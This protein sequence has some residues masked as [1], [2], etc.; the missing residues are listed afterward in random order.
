MCG[1]FAQTTPADVLVRLFKLVRPISVSPRFNLAPTQPVVAIRASPNGRFHQ[2]L[3]WG[4]VPPWAPDLKHGARLI[5]ARSETIF[6]KRS[7][8]EAARH[9]RCIIP[10]SGFYEWE[11]TPRGK[12]PI[13]FKPETDPVLCLAGLW[14]PWADS[15][16]AVTYTATILTTEANRTMQPYHSRMPVILQGSD[17]DTWLDAS[18]C[19]PTPLRP[20][21]RPAGEAAL[22]TMALTARVNKVSNDDPS[23]WDPRQSG[24]Q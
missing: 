15:S 19:D 2:H 13:L 16:G 20:L 24:H 23:C 18:I 5:N 21:L 6:S 11:N 12:L 10:A 8:A 3:R 7:F 9:R 17:V 1:R 4:L 22:K 14:S